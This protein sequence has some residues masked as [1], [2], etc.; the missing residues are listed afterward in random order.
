M[1]LVLIL[2]ASLYGSSPAGRTASPHAG[3]FLFFS[4]WAAAGGLIGFAVADKAEWAPFVGA[5]LGIALAAIL[6]G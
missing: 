2:G 6:M 3:L 5:L 1:F 4:Q